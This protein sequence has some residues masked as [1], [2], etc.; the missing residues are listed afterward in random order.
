MLPATR[1]RGGRCATLGGRGV[2]SDLERGR[3]APA[4][5]PLRGFAPCGCWRY[6][7]GHDLKPTCRSRDAPGSVG[8]SPVPAGVRAQVDDPR[9]G[10]P[11]PVGSRVLYPVTGGA[12][13]DR[14]RLRQSDQP[15]HRRSRDSDGPVRQGRRE[16]G[17]R[18]EALQGR[19]VR[20]PLRGGDGRDLSGETSACAG[21][22]TAARMGTRIASIAASRSSRTTTTSTSAT[23]TGGPTF[24][25]R[26]QLELDRSSDGDDP[27]RAHACQADSFC[28]SCT[29]CG[30]VAASCLVSLTRSVAAGSRQSLRAKTSV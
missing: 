22:G 8:R 1:P 26:S 24:I 23:R 4:W 10:D 30:A 28:A 9:A 13:E 2:P 3:A 21:G 14:P 16:G 11:V 18:S 7:R 19:R 5:K 15:V 29:G 27:M 20:G 12:G 25:S 17:D 6:H